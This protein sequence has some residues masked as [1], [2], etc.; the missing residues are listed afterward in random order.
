VLLALTA[1]PMAWMSLAP[2]LADQALWKRG[3]SATDVSVHGTRT[4]EDGIDSFDLVVAYADASGA[5]HKGKASWESVFYSIPAQAEPEVR[6]DTL[7]PDAF[8]LG[9]AI[10][11]VPWRV[12]LSVILSSTFVGLGWLALLVRR[13]IGRRV[14]RARR[15]AHDGRPVVLDL[16]FPRPVALQDGSVRYDFRRTNRDGTLV[17]DFVDFERAR[18]PVFVGGRRGPV[19]ILGLQ[20]AGSPGDVIALRDDL[21]PLDLPEQD[22]TRIAT[23]AYEATEGVYR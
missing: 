23:E 17:R 6:Y 21:H 3:A 18:G 14:R 16:V 2:V 8:V 19:Q 4:S 1:L 9:F 13:H 7:H 22:A 10:D 12:T 5:R 20:S 15:C 11:A